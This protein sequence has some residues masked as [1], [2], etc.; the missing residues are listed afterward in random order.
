MSLD[1]VHAA[2]ERVGARPWKIRGNRFR[3]KCP[4]HGGDGHN[5]EFRELYPGRVTFTCFSQDCGWDEMLSAL[6][7]TREDFYPAHEL[8][9]WDTGRQ[10]VPDEDELV[11]AI[12]RD[13]IARGEKLPASD[14]ERYQAAL[15]RLYQNKGAA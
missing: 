8:K 13:S 6:D 4:A 9:Q 11:V 2:C 12:A 10:Y 14:M 1:T 5:L 7:L 15:V 3:C